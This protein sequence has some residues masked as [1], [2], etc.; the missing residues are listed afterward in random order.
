MGWEFLTGLR[1]RSGHPGFHFVQT[2]SYKELT[3]GN[4]F[5]VDI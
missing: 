5:L 3:P 1:V 4:D 2:E